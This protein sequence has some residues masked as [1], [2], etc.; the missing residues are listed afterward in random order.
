MKLDTKAL[1]G[2]AGLICGGAMLLVGLAN[3]AWPDYGR[4]FLALTASLYP[5]FHATGTA[6]DL[7]AGVLYA[8]VDGAVCGLVFGWLYNRM[9]GSQEASIPVESTGAQKPVEP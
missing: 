1:A 6:G 3:L 8:L 4:A 2:A 9:T 7:A 5:G